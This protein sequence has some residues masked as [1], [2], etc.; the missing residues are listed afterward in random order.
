[1]NTLLKLTLA[2]AA[3]CTLASGA[4]H[5]RGA[6]DIVSETRVIDARVMRVTVEGPMGIVIKRGATPSLTIYAEK[7]YMPKIVTSQHG[8]NLRIDA[9]M[10]GMN[11]KLGKN[12]IRAELT[13]PGLSEVTSSGVGPS[14]ISGFTGDEI[15]LS[16]EGVGAVNFSG[17]YKRVTAKLA[18]VGDMT[19]NTGASDY[20]NVSHPGLGRVTLTGSARDM[21]A[22][23]SGMGNLDAQKMLADNVT[24]RMDGL[25]SASVYA[26]VAANLTLNGLGSVTAYGQPP[27]R[28][29]SVDGLGKVSWK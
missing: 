22:N 24:L 21:K 25:G 12:A 1:M 27:Q 2:S 10:D 15:K 19:L 14:D 13:L 5:A 17:N 7:R 20:V 23:L 16:L 29:V 4:V 9:D 26:K 11:I 6:D 18:G 8:D 28:N 3:A